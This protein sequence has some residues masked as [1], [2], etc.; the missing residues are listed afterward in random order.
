ML[1]WARE[2]ASRQPEVETRTA[3][4]GPLRADRQD[5]LHRVRHQ[6]VNR[7]APFQNEPSVLDVPVTGHH[8]DHEQIA[9]RVAL[10][11]DA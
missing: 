7:Q 6:V 11:P 2:K 8:A 4:Q 5:P 3:Q 1:P 9:R 10:V